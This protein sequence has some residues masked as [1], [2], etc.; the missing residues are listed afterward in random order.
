M[1]DHPR[2][3]AG[4]PLASPAGRALCLLILL[5]L[6]AGHAPLLADACTVDLS[7]R[8]PRATIYGGSPGAH[9]IHYLR[10][11]VACDVD[12]DGRQDVVMAEPGASPAGR[13]FAGRV[14]VLHD[15]A[16]L[17]GEVD[18]AHTADLEIWGEW[19]GGNLGSL[20]ACAD[21]DGDGKDDLLLTQDHPYSPALDEDLLLL[22]DL[23]PA[24]ILDLASSLP[25][26]RLYLPGGAIRLWSHR[27]GGSGSPF[28]FVTLPDNR[29]LGEPCQ[30]RGY[31]PSQLLVPEAP[32][33]SLD[34][35]FSVL[36]PEPGSGFGYAYAVGD[37]DG[38]GEDDLV[39]GAPYFRQVKASGD[40]TVGA[41]FLLTEIFL[42]QGDIDLAVQPADMEILGFGGS[43]NT[44]RGLAVGDH[45]GDGLADLLVGSPGVGHSP[46]SCGMGEAYLLRGRRNWPPVW[47]VSLRPPDLTLHGTAHAGAAGTQIAMADIDGDGSHEILTGDGGS[48]LPHPLDRNGSIHLIKGGP[49]TT[50]HITLDGG[51]TAVLFA[52]ADPKDYLVLSWPAD[53]DAD[54]RTD[55]FL[56]TLY[57]DGPGNLRAE[58]GE[59]YLFLGQ[60]LERPVADAGPDQV[61]EATGPDGATVRLDG[62]GSWDPDGDPLSWAWDVGPDDVVDAVGPQ[63]EV[64]L[65]LGRHVVHLQVEDAFCVSEPDEVVIEVVDTTPPEFLSVAFDGACLW[66][67][68]HDLLCYSLAADVVVR[69]IVDPAPD[70]AVT[71]IRSSQ[72][73]DATGDGHTSPDIQRPDSDTFCVRRERAGPRSA[74][75]AY[76][77]DLETQDFSGNSAGITATI[78]VPHDQRPSR[79]CP[80]VKK[81]PDGAG[82]S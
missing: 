60:G 39:I 12:G 30:V 24:G 45:D 15:A 33:W 7:E 10:S 78:H 9:L 82:G 26:S 59:V 36:D 40:Q 20:M 46:Q 2:A 25:D 6:P 79:R 63:P 75:R 18:L 56:G 71:E 80:R 61:V 72:P 74:P 53:L 13:L 62:S 51:S 70:L 41:A 55:L 57:G 1:P 31:T 50:D 3:A 4:A 21:L 48:G 34:Y 64:P 76:Q 66:P 38:S 43:P 69:D 47:D 19:G 58:A 35:C 77:V 22:L 81:D 28:I 27:P 29:S 44:G 37:V 67:P 16:S 52:G 49:I 54:G 8:S 42:R 11:L 68:R 32:I 17:Q 14:V 23:P 5:L 65:P 73:E